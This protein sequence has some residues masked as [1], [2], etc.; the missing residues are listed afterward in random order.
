[1]CVYGDGGKEDLEFAFQC[2]SRSMAL[3]YPVALYELSLFYFDDDVFENY[4]GILLA[5]DRHIDSIKEDYKKAIGL[6]QTACQ[7]NVADASLALG[8]MYLFGIGLKATI[9]KHSNMQRRMR[10]KGITPQWLV[11]FESLFWRERNGKGFEGGFLLSK[12]SGKA[13]RW[14]SQ[15]KVCGVLQRRMGGLKRIQRKQMN[16]SKEMKGKG[17]NSWN[18]VEISSKADK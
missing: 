12:G 3:G 7:L 8:M 18:F 1:M 15:K 9:R 4:H 11:P 13:R 2:F 17:R 16:G 14:W 10:R 5:S 6:L